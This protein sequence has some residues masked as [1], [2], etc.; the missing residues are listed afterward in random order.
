MTT[1]TRNGRLMAEVECW[2]KVLHLRAGDKDSRHY[3][4]PPSRLLL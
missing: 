2:E 3:G 4:W 1:G